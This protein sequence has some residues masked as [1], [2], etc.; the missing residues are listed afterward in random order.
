MIISYAPHHTWLKS[1][2]EDAV[3]VLGKSNQAQL[4]S[5]LKLIGETQITHTVDV[6]SQ[7]IL[8]WFIPLYTEKIGSR[9]NGKIFDIYGTTLGKESPYTY[10]ALILKEND[11]PIGATLFS[12]RKDTLSIAYRMYPNKWQSDI[13]QAN[14]SL[15]TEY[16]INLHAFQRGFKKISH[17]RDRNPYGPNA[18]IGLA[19]FKLS[20]G[21]KARIPQETE[22]L[23]FDTDTATCDTLIFERPHTGRN[24]KRA[25]LIC[26]EDN[27]GKYVQVTK[28][29][30]LLEVETIIRN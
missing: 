4:R 1:V 16:L 5:T 18:Y 27:I 19:A 29:P 20:I 9:E 13:L 10:Y 17:G 2:H 6:L 24:I 15:Y 28:Y 22:T 21:C 23:M 7:E 25:Y 3:S 30:H 8:D 26:T 11:V 14:P 12:E